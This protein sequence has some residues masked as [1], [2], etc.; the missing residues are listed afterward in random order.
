MRLFV[1]VFAAAAFENS[2][3]LWACE[4]R[5]H[6]KH[7]DDDDQDPYCISK[8]LFHA[9]IGWLLFKLDPPPPFDNVQMSHLVGSN[10]QGLT[11]LR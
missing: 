6:H 4:H 5:R 7:V 9:H 11:P 10:C 8:G 2:A 1:L 3:L